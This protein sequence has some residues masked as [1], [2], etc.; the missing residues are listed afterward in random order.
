M[1]LP[2]WA[3]TPNLVVLHQTI[4][5]EVGV[6]TY[7]AQRSRS[8][9]VGHGCALETP[10]L[11]WVSIPNLIAV[12]VNSNGM[13]IHTEIRRKNWVNRVPLFKVIECDTHRSSCDFLLVIHS[14]HTIRYNEV[15]SLK[16]DE[17]NLVYRTWPK[18]KQENWN[19]KKLSWC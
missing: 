6:Q 2:T 11:V 3:T 17:T 15:L 1:S 5:V 19:N 7:R 4:R 10:L 9:R 12:L 13:S 18:K 14:N 16:L 8:I